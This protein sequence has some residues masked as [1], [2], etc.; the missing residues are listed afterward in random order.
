MGAGMDTL[1]NIFCE[2]WGVETL[3]NQVVGTFALISI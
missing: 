1:T 2:H 3:V